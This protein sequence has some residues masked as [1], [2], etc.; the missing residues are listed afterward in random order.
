MCLRIWYLGENKDL[1][2][3]KKPEDRK[4]GINWRIENTG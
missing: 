1:T 4:Y 3:R 2:E